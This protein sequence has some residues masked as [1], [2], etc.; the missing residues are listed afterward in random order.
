MRN[1]WRQARH[2]TVSMD[3]LVAMGTLAAWGYSVVVTVAPELVMEAGIEPVTY[4]DSSAMIIGLILDRALAGGPRPVAGQ[5][6]RG[7]P[8]GAPGAYGA[9]RPR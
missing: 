3:T 4:F 6:R 8:R 1:A 9:T 5:R 2:G 7:R